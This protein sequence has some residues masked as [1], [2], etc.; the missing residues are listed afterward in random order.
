MPIETPAAQCGPFAHDTVG[1]PRTMGLVMLALVPATLFGLWQFGWP[2]IWLFLATLAGALLA[3]ILSLWFAGKPIRPDLS[4]GT[5]LLTGWLLAMTLPPWAPWWIGVVGALLAIVV[6]KQ[7]FGGVGQNLFNPAMVARVALLIAFPLEMTS[8]VAPTPL[9]SAEAPGLV[10]SLAITFGGQ[11]F[12]AFSGATVLGQVRTELGQGETLATILPDLYAPLSGAVGTVAGSLGETSALLLLLGGLF[13]LY[14]RVITWHIPVAL[15]G[16]IAVL[17]ALM[18]LIDPEHYAGPLYHLVSGA[19]LLG[20]FFI[21]T[22]PVTSPVSAR[23]QLL[24]GAGCGL[25]IYVIRTWAGYP[26][27]VAFAVLLMNAC[28][29]LIDHYVKPRIYGRDRRGQPLEYAN[30]VETSR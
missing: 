2:A 17:A 18:H 16:T 15:L 6:A 11:G 4:D 30:D 19:T 26:E 29:P 5:A 7:V 10:E 8:F 9:F 14:K 24:F 27:G 12:D 23:G 21:A 20:A 3:E 13:L 25:L 28:A 1:I 22:D